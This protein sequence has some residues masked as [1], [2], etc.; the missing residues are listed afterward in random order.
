M[1]CNARVRVGLAEG[2]EVDPGLERPDVLR[3]AVGEGPVRVARPRLGREVVVPLHVRVD[4]ER[5][6]LWGDGDA[7]IGEPELATVSLVR[8]VEKHDGRVWFCEQS[9]PIGPKAALC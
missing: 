2:E 9:F 3:R 7:Q 6:G 1:W 5:A 4:D 8:V